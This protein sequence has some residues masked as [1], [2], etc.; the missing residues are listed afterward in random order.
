MAMFSS[1]F[2]VLAKDAFIRLFRYAAD[3][4][5]PSREHPTLL[6]MVG[7]L[8]L[9]IQMQIFADDQLLAMNEQGMGGPF[10]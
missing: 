7:F 9:F 5:E 4:W 8:N 6:F 10:F 3:S 1:V 2:T